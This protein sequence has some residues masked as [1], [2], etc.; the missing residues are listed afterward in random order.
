[1]IVLI[2]TLYIIAGIV[3]IG[4][5]VP[6]LLKLIAVKD[7]SEFSFGTW[8]IWLCTQSVSAAYFVTLGDIFAIA[9]AVAWV[10]FYALMFALIVYY[11]PHKAIRFERASRRPVVASEK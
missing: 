11:R 7:S 9:V 5:G 3:S 6:Q 8:L 2:Q 4:A 1:M 10:A